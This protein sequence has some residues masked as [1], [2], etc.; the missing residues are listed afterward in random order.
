MEIKERVLNTSKTRKQVRK[1]GVSSD[2]IYFPYDVIFN[3]IR[4]LL[5]NRKIKHQWRYPKTLNT[6]NASWAC[7]LASKNC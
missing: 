4:D 6:N 7:R 2:A 5:N 1:E 3:S